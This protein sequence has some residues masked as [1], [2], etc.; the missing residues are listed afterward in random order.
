MERSK[1]KIFI[2]DD[3]SEFLK[4]IKTLLEETNY[5]VGTCQKPT[6]SIFAIRNFKPDC[7]LLDLRMPIWDGKTALAW[8]RRQFPALAIIVCTAIT[9]FNEQELLR[10]GVLYIIQKPFATEL[11]LNTIERIILEQGYRTAA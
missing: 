4:E 7:L 1:K 6:E 10:S 2:L 11:L 3:D 8:I 9:D 5:E